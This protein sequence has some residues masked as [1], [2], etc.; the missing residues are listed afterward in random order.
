[1]LNTVESCYSLFVGKKRTSD[2]LW[3]K[4]LNP[5]VQ[6][7][8]LRGPRFGGGLEEYFHWVIRVALAEVDV[9]AVMYAMVSRAH[10]KWYCGMFEMWRQTKGRPPEPG[11]V[12]RQSEHYEGMVAPKAPRMGGGT[13]YHLWKPY[14]LWD[15]CMVPICGGSLDRISKLEVHTIVIDQP[16]ANRRGRRMYYEDT[17]WRKERN[18]GTQ[19]LRPPRWRRK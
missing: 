10:Q 7:R 19:A 11:G 1:L 5:R 15:Q 18:K 9:E 3:T 12:E 4:Y 16:P 13:K 8:I 14:C 17:D 6:A 2:L